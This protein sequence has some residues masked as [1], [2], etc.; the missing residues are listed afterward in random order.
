MSEKERA[1]FKLVFD[2]HVNVIRGENDTG[3]SSLL[4]SLYWVFGANPAQQH[5]RWTE[6]KVT[7]VLHFSV[8]EQ[9]FAVARRANRLCLFSED[10]EK[11]LCTSS[12][13]A[14]FA[15]ALAEVLGT[16]L[17]LTSRKGTP[18]VPPPA[19]LFLPFYIDQDHGWQNPWQS[20]AQLSQYKD[21]KKDVIQ[22]HSGLKPDEYFEVKAN[23]SALRV[24]WSEMLAHRAVVEKAAVALRA[25]AV[26]DALTLNQAEYE[27]AI[28]QHLN[29]LRTLRAQRF[30]YIG[31]MQDA[32]AQRVVLNEQL[33]IARRALSEYDRDVKS[34]AKHEGDF[35]LCPTCGTEHRNSFRNRFSIIDDREQ[36]IALIND[37]FSEISK[38][39]QKVEVTRSRIA[40]VEDVIV[41]IEETL[42]IRNG[43]IEFKDVLAAEGRRQA[44][45]VFDEQS[46]LIDAS[47]R[48]RETHIKAL[49]V[50]IQELED[51]K[52]KKA[53]ESFFAQR[54]SRNLRSLG[55]PDL[56]PAQSQ[57][58]FAKIKQTGS[59]QP[60]AVL[61]YVFSFLQTLEEYSTALA[62]P[63]VIDSPIQQEQDKVNTKKMIN[64]IFAERPKDMQLVLGTVSLHGENVSGKFLTLE[65]KY[66][67]LS[68]DK[69]AEVADE[70]QSITSAMF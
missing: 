37:L 29:S 67:L 25:S 30:A 6:A 22:Y 31:E 43:E 34:L 21:W 40:Q 42:A 35:I 62:A 32:V 7:G 23:L 65:E 10:G 49:E 15:P 9:R 36:C 46:A 17:T 60:R 45:S 24:A 18:E 14:E 16:K 61:A 11:I 69:F 39:S 2:P 26:S 13:T 33:K 4:K 5:V 44:L 58:M 59:D 3:K 20:F 63:L 8:D 57:K 53:I 12:L 56:K 52:R 27:E 68:R 64:F 19:Y 70:L 38:L 28:H 47:L 50:R 41:E 66:A 1:A 51:K 48:E 54:I 55:V